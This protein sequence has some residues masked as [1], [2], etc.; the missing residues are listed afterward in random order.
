MVNTNTSAS[1]GVIMSMNHLVLCMD[2]CVKVANVNYHMTI[3]TQ[4]GEHQ[5]KDMLMFWVFFVIC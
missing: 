5:K 3:V 1:T 4:V 2:I